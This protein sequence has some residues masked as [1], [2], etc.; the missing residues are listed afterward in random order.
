VPLAHAPRGASFSEGLRLEA[1]YTW[2]ANEPAR[3][4]ADHVVTW[5]TVTGGWGKEGIYSRPQA[6]SGDHQNG[7]PGG[8]FDNDSIVSELIFLAKVISSDNTV[9][10]PRLKT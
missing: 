1:S 3:R 2:Y 8:K 10:E 6:A 4:I 7:W 9:P 5:Q